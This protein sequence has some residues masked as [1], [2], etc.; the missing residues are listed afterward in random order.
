[1]RVFAIILFKAAGDKHQPDN[2]ALSYNLENY[3]ALLYNGFQATS[4]Y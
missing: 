4:Q 2:F 3:T 1:M